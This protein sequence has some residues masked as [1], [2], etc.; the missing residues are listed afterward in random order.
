MRT[1]NLDPLA[2][3]AAPSDSRAIAAP[4][5]ARFSRRT[6]ILPDVL[7]RF[8]ERRES[9]KRRG[10]KHADLAIKIMMNAMIGVLGAPSGRFFDPAVANAV[11]GFGRLMLE[12]TRRAFEAAGARVLYGDTDSVFVQLDES[13]SQSDAYAAAESLR[14]RVQ[15][16]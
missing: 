12:R 4:N 2:H 11:T 14:A 5:G 1:F 15:Q 7:E 6:A 10:D 8:A 16:E 13:L 3:A 9:A